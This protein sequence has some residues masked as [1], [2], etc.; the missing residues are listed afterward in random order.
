VKVAL[1][2]GSL[3]HEARQKFWREE[4]YDKVVVRRESG[5]HL[6]EDEK[7]LILALFRRRW[8]EKDI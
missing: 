2:D 8:R 4:R 5:K 3:V 7:S 1:P 6:L